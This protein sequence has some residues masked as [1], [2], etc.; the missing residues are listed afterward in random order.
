[1]REKKELS[2][3][4]SKSYKNYNLG[5]SGNQNER[6]NKRLSE[7]K[8]LKRADVNVLC[9]WVITLPKTIEKDTKEEDKFLK[10]C[11]NFY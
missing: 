7:V 5:L 9:N 3:D 10:K 11:I 6:L 8:V 4:E 2:I 1:M